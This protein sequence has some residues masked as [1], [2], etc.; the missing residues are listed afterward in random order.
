MENADLTVNQPSHHTEPF[1][2]PRAGGID[3]PSPITSTACK[4]RGWILL[5]G[6][7]ISSAAHAGAFPYEVHSKTLDN[8]LSIHVVPMASP[9]VAAY[10]TWM[11]VGSRD[12]VDAGRTGFA[13]FF[14]HLMFYGTEQLGHEA[15][16]REV[17]TLGADEN[18]WTWLDDTVYHQ[19]LASSQ[20]PRLVEIEADRFTGLHLTPDNV[21]RE[22]GAVYGEF[23]K[24]Q[25]SPDIQLWETLYGTAFATHTYTHD[26]IGYEA[27]IAAMPDAHEYAQQFFDRYYR[28]E[29]AVIV[30]VG[31]VVVD[32][33][34]AKIEAEYRDWKPATEPRAE[35]PVEPP[36]TSL[37]TAYVPWPTPTA[38]R[39]A[40]GW[41][42]PAHDPD[43]PR[44]ASLQ[45]TADMLGSKVGP[46]YT[47]L[48][49]DEGLV[50]DLSVGRDDLVDP[51]LFVVSADVKEDDDLE[52]VQSIVLEEVA[53]LKVEVDAGFLERTRSHNKY[54]FLTGLDD[55]TAVANAL[56]WS[57]RRGGGPDAIDRFYV[58]YDSATAESVQGATATFLIPQTLTV[59][60]LK[61]DPDGV[62]AAAAAKA[63]AQEADKVADETA[64]PSEGGGQ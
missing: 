55:P 12:E 56:G 32:D 17:L 7:T 14:E 1:H 52:R 37:R 59:V 60:T 36:Q 16:E 2:V 31:D 50:Y 13:H 27:D 10:Q 44:L 54:R 64:Q 6:L 61:T 42:V 53:K 28:P 43:D 26:T 21:K 22:S 35:V 19:T 57:N 40:L 33:V 51:G 39:I 3:G 34:F 23:R 58:N 45:L 29:N 8:G 4:V 20:L 9:G 46:L 49:K 38:A 48:I 25:A 18:A 47:R 11:A 24:G 41:K 15:R 63:A 5:T 30:V 62:A